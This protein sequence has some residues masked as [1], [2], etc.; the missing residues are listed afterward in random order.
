MPA[1]CLLKPKGDG[2][3]AFRGVD[4]LRNDPQQVKR[5]VGGNGLPWSIETKENRARGSPWAAAA[6]APRGFPRSFSPP[7]PLL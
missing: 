2:S 7:P 3:C 5:Y 6:R 1:V 4:Q